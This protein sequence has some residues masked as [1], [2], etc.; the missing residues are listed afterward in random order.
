[1]ATDWTNQFSR[2]MGSAEVDPFGSQEMIVGNLANAFY[3]QQHQRRT[4]RACLRLCY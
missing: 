1:M 2:I 3:I 4:S